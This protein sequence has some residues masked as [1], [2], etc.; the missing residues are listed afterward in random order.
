MSSPVVPITTTNPA[1]V[2]RDALGP[3]YAVGVAECIVSVV[4]EA[5]RRPY[6]ARRIDHPL[7]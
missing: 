1:I 7:I 5:S 4:G 3:G 2:W 6:H